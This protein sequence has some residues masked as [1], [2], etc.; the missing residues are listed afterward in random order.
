MTAL[1]RSAPKHLISFVSDPE[2]WN[3][4]VFE[5]SICKEVEN[6]TGQLTPSDALLIGMLITQVNAFVEAHAKVKE[7]G[8]LYKYTAGEATSPWTK[9]RNETL[10]R[11]IKL[12]AELGLVARGRPKKQNKVSS[13]DELFN[14]S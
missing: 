13:V 3:P 7:L 5:E 8:S 1:K 12:L 6:Q 4:V 9:I 10:D 11:C 14:A 2:N